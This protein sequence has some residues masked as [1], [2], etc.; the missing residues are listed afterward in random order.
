MN[1]TLLTIIAEEATTVLV[2]IFMLLLVTGGT[3]LG[4]RLNDLIGAKQL[5]TLRAILD[6]A[7]QRAVARAKAKGLTG[8][9]LQESVA[10]Y[11]KQ[12]MGD[13]L[14][15]TGWTE[16]NL[17]KRAGAQEAISDETASQPV[18]SPI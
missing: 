9:A 6:P 11:L 10:S 4:K 3:W 16:E 15:R 5:E 7:V 1:D 13:T 8:E 14:D 12:T 2:S 17:R 18:P